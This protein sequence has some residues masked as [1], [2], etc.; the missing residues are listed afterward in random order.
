VFFVLLQVLKIVAFSAWPGSVKWK[1]EDE[2][3]APVVRAAWVARE[4]SPESFGFIFEF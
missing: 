4:I 2:T 3:E 1:F